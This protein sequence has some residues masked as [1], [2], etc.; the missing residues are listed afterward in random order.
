M[1]F[2]WHWWFK[3]T[4]LQ[5]PSQ[6]TNVY[7]I[8]VQCSETFANIKP[9]L[10]VFYEHLFDVCEDSSKCEKCLCLAGQERKMILFKATFLT[11]LRQWQISQIYV[12]VEGVR[13]RRFNLP[14]TVKKWIGRFRSGCSRRNGHFNFTSIDWVNNRR[15][16][17]K[18]SIK[19]IDQNKEYNRALWHHNIA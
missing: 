17:W 4:S 9:S 1:R 16:V 15:A 12:S 19:E 3:F 7:H 5:H 8:I 14:S 18:I 6:N 11:W 13:I 10:T 2:T